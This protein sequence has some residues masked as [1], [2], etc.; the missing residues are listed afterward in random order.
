MMQNSGDILPTQFI[1][2]LND[3]GFDINR[4]DRV[5]IEPLQTIV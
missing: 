1:K 2:A 5:G 4:C 3:L